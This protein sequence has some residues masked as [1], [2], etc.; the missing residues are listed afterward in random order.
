MFSHEYYLLQSR[1]NEIE[2][3]TPEQNEEILET[4]NEIDKIAENEVKLVNDSQETENEKPLKS[5][6]PPATNEITRIPEESSEEDEDT[7][8]EDE[9]DLEGRT[10]TTKG[11]EVRENCSENV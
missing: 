9:R 3:P 10:Y 4:I 7:D 8:E 2:P 5:Y 1:E 6:S 11:Q